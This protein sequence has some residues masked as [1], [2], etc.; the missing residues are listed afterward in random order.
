MRNEGALVEAAR[1]GDE[2]AFRLLVEQYERPILGFLY[3][4]VADSELARDLAQDT[5]LAAYHAL[6]QVRGGPLAFRAW[7]Y[8]IALNLARQSLRRRRLIH[9]LPWAD[10]Y[11]PTGDALDADLTAQAVHDALLTL[12]HDLRVALVLRLVHG[13]GY[14]EIAAITGASEAAIKMRVLRA[15]RAFRRVYQAGEQDGSPNTQDQ[16]PAGR[17][18]VRQ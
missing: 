5:F 6:P 9:W 14:S 4:I 8:K 18:E 1:R 11:T 16:P 15:R 2:S 12:P 13:F 10:T 17:L 3:R 7:L